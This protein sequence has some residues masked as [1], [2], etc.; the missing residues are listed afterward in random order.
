MMAFLVLLSLVSVCQPKKIIAVIGSSTAFGTGA[1][2][3]D[4]SWVN[5]TKKYFKDLGEI[6]TIYNIALGGLTTYPGMPTG[7]VPP[8]G[9]PAPDPRYNVTTA[10]SFNPD[11]VLVNF[12]TND[13]VSDYTVTE[14]MFNLRTIYQTVIN[15]GKICYITTSQP[16]NTA[17]PSQEAILKVERDSILAEF[18]I[19]SLN[20]YNP[21]VAADS[22]TINP[23]Y[24]FDGTHVNNGGHQLLFQ[25]VKAAGILAGSPLALASWSLVATARPRD[26]LLSWTGAGETDPVVFT[27]QRSKDGVAFADQ[28]GENGLVNTP[29]ARYSWDD[30]DPLP[31]RSFYRL[32]VSRANGTERYSPVVSL[33]WAAEDWG[34]GSIFIPGGGPQLQAEIQSIKNQN[35]GMSILNTAGAPVLRGSYSLVAPSTKITIDISH[36]AHGTYFI[37]IIGEDGHVNTRS[38]LKP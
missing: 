29:D 21:V 11:V 1:N 7:F 23:I 19:Y 9:K 20:F 26:I 4:S 10:L 22:L 16:R 32:K 37:T 14:T 24:N 2:P 18:P 6:D 8:A 38:F 12:P 34:I 33:G 13:A 30:K 36:L 27:I 15:A 25:Q 3:I 31:G 17:S 5:L 35:I 28:G